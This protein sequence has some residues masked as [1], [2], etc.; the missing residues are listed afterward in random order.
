MQ[1][2]GLLAVLATTALLLATLRRTGR[3]PRLA[4]VFGWC[5]Y[6]TMEAVTN[7][8]IDASAA[9]LAFAATVLLTRGRRIAGG[10]VLGLAIA[11][12][13]LPVLIAPP[14]GRRRPWVI[15]AAA[16]ARSRSSTSR[17]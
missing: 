15:A 2:L 5:P 12:K 6:V 17:T 1:L 3:D 9:F 14:L 13:F 7:A 8:H 10:V 4:A 16:S 11:T